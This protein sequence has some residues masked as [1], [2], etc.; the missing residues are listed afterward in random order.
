MSAGDQFEAQCMIEKANAYPSGD[1]RP[2]FGR[3]RELVLL[4]EAMRH[5]EPRVIHVHGI[6]G[7]GKSTLILEFA[8]IW[9]TKKRTVLLLDGRSIE[10]TESG[11][12]S[13][14]SN[15]SRSMTRL[16]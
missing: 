16:R 8:A 13:P 14:S 7:I 10:P 9:R 12:L 4:S 15:Q 2:V 5:S 6:S 3:E 11:F 1:P